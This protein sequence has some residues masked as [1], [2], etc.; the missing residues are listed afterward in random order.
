M[1]KTK[2]YLFIGAPGAGKTT[3]AKLIAEK[4]GAKHLWADVERHKLFPNPTHSTEESNELYRQLNAA[5]DYLLK[6]GKSVVFDTNFNHRADRDHLRAIAAGAGA[7]TVIIWMVTPYNVAH[8]RAVGSGEQ[9]NGYITQM[10]NEEFKAIVEKL[11]EPTEDEKVIKI[12]G[13]NID[14]EQV[15][16]LL[17]L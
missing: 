9:R 12:D 5:T 1:S 7:E 3:I 17:K 6:Q 8:D 13:T 16:E 14:R 11:E 10:T 2:L 15:I 4:T